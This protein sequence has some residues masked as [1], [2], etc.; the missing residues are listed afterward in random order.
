M[1]QAGNLRGQVEDGA[2]GAHLD[3]RVD[4]EEA[5]DAAVAQHGNQLGGA[6]GAALGFFP[7][8]LGQERALFV[9]GEP[10]GV[11]GTVVEEPEGEHAE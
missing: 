1:Q 5:E 7:R 8:E 10:L 6:G 3:E 4:G 11:R 9:L 2:I